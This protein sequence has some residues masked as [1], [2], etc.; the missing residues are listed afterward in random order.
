MANTIAN[1]I[2]PIGKSL[3]MTV[4]TASTSSSLSVT[5]P[6]AVIG[7]VL[8][9]NLTANN[10]AYVSISSSSGSVTAPTT[11]VAQFVVPVLGGTQVTVNSTPNPQTGTVWVNAIAV[12]GGTLVIT[13]LA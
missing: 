9:T 13:P 10:T 3:L 12:G 8:V 2:Q 4:T 1:L 5:T 6:E 11:S 7:G